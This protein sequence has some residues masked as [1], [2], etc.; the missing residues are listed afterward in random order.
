MTVEIKHPVGFAGV[1]V[2][3]GGSSDRLTLMPS[4]VISNWYLPY[5]ARNDNAFAEGTWEMWVMLAK[6]I[7]ELEERRSS[8]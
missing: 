6:E 2:A 1:I 7:L 8:V 5:N 4:S 3:E